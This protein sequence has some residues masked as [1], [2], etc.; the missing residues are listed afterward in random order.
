[1]SCNFVDY[2]S[3]RELH[4]PTQLQV[5]EPL[6]RVPVYFL[7]GAIVPMLRPGIESLAPVTDS[8]IDSFSANPGRLNGFLVPGPDRTSFGL[9]F[10]GGTLWTQRVGHA[11]V[12]FVSSAEGTTFTGVNL[13]I[14]APGVTSVSVDTLGTLPQVEAG[15]TGSCAGCFALEPD[16]PWVQ[17]GLDGLDGWTIELE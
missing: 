12:G 11:S 5:E 6:E 17:V 4:G 1:M 2:W 13:R 7:E 3:G 15:G 14:Y 8:S 10:D 9:P 16:S